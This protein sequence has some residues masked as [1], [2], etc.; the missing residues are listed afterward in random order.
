MFKVHG[1]LFGM[2]WCLLCLLFVYVLKGMLKVQG[3]RFYG[4]K[5]A[6]FSLLFMGFTVWGSRFRVSGFDCLGFAVFYFKV[7]VL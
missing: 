5:C 1:F 6:A 2:F 7:Y 4:L 3:L